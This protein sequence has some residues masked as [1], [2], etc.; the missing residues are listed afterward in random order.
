MLRPCRLPALT[1]RP[2]RERFLISRPCRLPS[3]ISR[4]PID[5]VATAYETPPSDTKRETS[6][7][8]IAGELL[9]ILPCID[10]P[11]SECG[12]ASVVPAEARGESGCGGRVSAC[13]AT[14]L[15]AARQSS[16]AHPRTWRGT[17]GPDES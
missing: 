11:P 17:C 9:G 5:P 15:A 13:K 14:A 1:S 10:S 7:T 12:P 6:A 16:E 2:S 8:T 3:L 4:E